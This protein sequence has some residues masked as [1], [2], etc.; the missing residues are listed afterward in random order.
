[1]HRDS[2]TGFSVT[3]GKPLTLSGFVSRRCRGLNRWP[4]RARR[5]LRKDQVQLLTLRMRDV[6]FREDKGLSF[7]FQKPWTL[8][9]KWRVQHCREGHRQPRRASPAQLA[10]T[11]SPLPKGRL[12]P[13]AASEARSSP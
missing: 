5:S 2:N 8:N 11:R 13:S 1:M 7:R 12:G 6:S 3:V 4:L 9:S 10:E